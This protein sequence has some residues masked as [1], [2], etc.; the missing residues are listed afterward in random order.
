MKKPLS[1]LNHKQ[2]LELVTTYRSPTVRL[3]H[4]RTIRRKIR[5]Y[6]YSLHFKKSCSFI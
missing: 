3:N 4:V 1:D 6:K 5:Q 2:L